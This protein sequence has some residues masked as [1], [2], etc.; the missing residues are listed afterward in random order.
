MQECH[1]L[2]EDLPNWKNDWGM[3]DIFCNS[4]TSRSAGQAILLKEKRE[5][6]DHV[7]VLEGRIHV[8]KLR[9]SGEVLSLINIYGPNKEIDRR[10]FLEKLQQF[11][12]TYDYGDHLIIGGDF[13]IV[14]D[15]TLDKYNKKSR[16]PIQETQTWSQRKL[17]HLK[18]SFNLMDIWRMQNK[19]NKK[20]HMVPTKSISKMQTGLLF[21]T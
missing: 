6:I 13:N 15:N 3:G 11:L 4:F 16:E 20:I 1:I 14:P 10:P 17:H 5:I 9:M 21:D 8:L 7:V 2:D 19:N 18:D 12:S